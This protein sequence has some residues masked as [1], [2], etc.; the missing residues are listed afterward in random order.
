ALAQDTAGQKPDKQAK[1]RK[2]KL[3]FLATLGYQSWKP[4]KVVESLKKLGYEGIEWST[5]HIDVNNPLPGLRELAGRTRDAGLEVSRISTLED[6]VCPND[7]ERKK[8]I[9]R[10]IRVIE[11]AGECGIS[12]VGVMPGPFAWRASAPKVGKNITESK[13]WDLVFEAYEAFGKAAKAAGVITSTE[14]VFGMIA[15]DF[16]THKFMMDKLD[17]SVHKVNHDPSHGILYG[18]LDVGWVIRQWGDRIGHVHLKDAVGI[19]ERGKFLFPL[20]GEGMVNW[21]AFFKALDDIG[22]ERF[23]SVEFESFSYYQKILKGDPE[24][25]ARISIENVKALTKF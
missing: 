9:D 25:A 24:A 1:R 15:H 20:L 23:C 8:R 11:A 3:A 16:Y 6:L 18:N 2:W 7:N 13:A 14:A 17:S 21:G 22:Y 5:K 19:P 10:I 4:A 12:N